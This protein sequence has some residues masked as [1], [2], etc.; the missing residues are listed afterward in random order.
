MPGNPAR[1]QDSIALSDTCGYGPLIMISKWTR[2]VLATTFVGLFCVDGPYVSGQVERENPYKDRTVNYR[3]DARKLPAE[4]PEPIVIQGV[5]RVAMGYPRVFTRIFYRRELVTGAPSSGLV[6][7]ARTA[8][9]DWLDLNI[10]ESNGRQSWWTSVLDTGAGGYAVNQETAQRFRLKASWDAIFYVHG[11][12]G[13]V[14][15]GVSPTLTVNIAGSSGKLMETP[16]TPFVFVQDFA[17]FGIELQPFNPNYQ[18]LPTGMNIV[19]M[20]AIRRFTLEIDSTSMTPELIGKP[21]DMSDDEALAESLKS[22]V[23]GPTVR[24]FPTSYRPTNSFVVMPMQYRN[25]LQLSVTDSRGSLPNQSSTP[26]LMGVKTSQ[27]E[28]EFIGDFLFDTGS[29]MTIISRQQ[30]YQLGLIKSANPA[31]DNAEF[32]ET[33]KGAA[34]RDLNVPGFTIKSLAMRNPAGQI[35][36]WQ[37]VPVLVKDVWIQQPNGTRRVRDGIIGNNL[38]LPST[39]GEFTNEGLDVAAAPF[40]RIWIHGP[41]AELWIERPVA[42]VEEEAEQT[43]PAEQ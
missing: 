30:A 27:G 26:M 40:P 18:V 8:Q 36:E 4:A 14:T 35:I 29:P 31:F 10:A 9:G 11:V 28:R 39:N 20:P 7:R 5:K 37:D 42:A 15:K 2:L 32:Q 34:G 22:V 21:V 19:G 17:Q 38:F 13:T 6:Q 24:V 1:A 43:E 16:S 41:S 3:R 33:I 12:D 23:A 25:F